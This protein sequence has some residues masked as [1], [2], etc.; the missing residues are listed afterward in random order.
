[1]VSRNPPCKSRSGSPFCQIDSAAP[2]S[3][4]CWKFSWSSG[5]IRSRNSSALN[6]IAQIW[7]DELR[8]VQLFSVA[9][10]VGR[11]SSVVWSRFRRQRRRR[12]NVA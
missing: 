10:I 1:M 9:A 2:S 12:Y 6:R 11:G 5:A 7:R 8:L 4:K 3:P